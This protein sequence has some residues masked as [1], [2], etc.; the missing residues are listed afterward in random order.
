[1]CSFADPFTQN[2]EVHSESS[3]LPTRWLCLPAG[4][5]MGPGAWRDGLAIENVPL[6]QGPAAIHCW[7]LSWET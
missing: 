1:M 6:S 5:R 3:T 4:S 7:C 2:L